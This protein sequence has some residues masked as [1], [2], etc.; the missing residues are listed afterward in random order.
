MAFGERL[1]AAGSVLF[2][3]SAPAISARI[4]PRMSTVGSGGET[5]TDLTDPRLAEYLR[6]AG[7]GL[8]ASGAVINDFS[9][10]SIGTAWRC[11]SVICGVTK[12][13][14]WDLNLRLGENSRA[15]AEKERFREVL[16]VKPNNRQTPGE[17]KTMLQL[18]KL[19]RG[20]GY[21][22]KI[23]SMGR[24]IALWPLD[25][26]RMQ[27]IE[28]ADLSLT[29]RYTRKDGTQIDFAQGEIMHLR[30]LSW[31]GITGLSVIRYMTESAGLALQ[32]RMGAA[33]MLRN[34]QITPGYL[35][36]PNKLSD[37]AY[38]R[39]KDDI[40]AK[41]GVD[42]EDAGKMQILEEGL[43]FQTTG[44]TAEDAQLIGLMGLS[45][46]DIGMFYGVPPH[47]YGDTDKSTSWGTGIE[48]QNLGFLQYTIEP[49]LADWREVIKR[50]C[51]SEKGMDPR[52]YLHIDLKGFL[53]ADAAGR[54]AYLA[55]ALGAGGGKP[56]MTQQE[57]RAT[58]DLQPRD[59][60]KEPWVD[61]LP[62][63]GLSG[64]VTE[65][66]N[67]AQGQDPANP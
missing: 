28:N 9:V 23:R 55:R 16:T 58:E 12:T 11:A 33:K 3:G 29:Y 42:A 20:N 40:D 1:I 6:G 35:K 34:G 39:L 52:L 30:G 25:P 48:Q 46:T 14:P 7:G 63:V 10:L 66:F 24:I 15:P 19:Q 60:T 31:D 51:L 64:R 67:G 56:W 45:R 36:S 27:V 61:V 41:S 53:R 13:L 37:T 50:D 18:H 54:S 4:E 62:E 57:A 38:N 17:F 43:E 8:S 47:L 21:A 22:M 44:L 49:H 65:T 32:A 26:N 2:G 5:F 59:V